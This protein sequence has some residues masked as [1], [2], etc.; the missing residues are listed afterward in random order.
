MMSLKPFIQLLDLCTP[1]LM[2][3]IGRLSTSSAE[4]TNSLYLICL[5]ILVETAYLIPESINRITR[6][7]PIG[8]I[9]LMVLPEPTTMTRGWSTLQRGR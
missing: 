5:E 2:S 4:M 8:P 9:R 3:F 6:L 7:I 1:V